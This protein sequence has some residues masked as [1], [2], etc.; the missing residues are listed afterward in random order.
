MQAE[1]QWQEVNSAFSNQAAHF[2][3]DDFSNPILTAWRKRIYKHV[4]LFLKPESHIL[5]INAGT[6]IDAV[7]FARQGH[8]VH[9]TDLSDGMIKALQNKKERFS[10][11]D[12]ISIQQLSFEN[13]DQ[14]QGKFDLIFSN[15]G[16]LNCTDD[17]R[18]VT[19]HLPD[20]LEPGGLVTW[21]VMPHL[22]PWEWLWVLK[23]KFKMALRRL[24]KTGSD[25]HLEGFFFRTYY[26]SLT[27]IKEAMPM[28]FT[29]LK[30]ES[31]GCFSP[32]PAAT[33][34]VKSFP[35]I[36]RIL[37]QLDVSLSSK[38]PFN[39]WGDHLIVTFRLV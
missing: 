11:Q 20:L 31:L 13:L 5:E 16:G 15:F 4:E 1:K 2:D 37:N 14:V 32:P 22:C 9:A 12:R 33:D 21:V 8:R 27:Q 17:L 38:F 39:R 35:K 18:R 36:T 3:D 7:H 6:G 24:G 28:G 19:K 23:G 29:L 10:L 30:T 26:F 25:S 34:F